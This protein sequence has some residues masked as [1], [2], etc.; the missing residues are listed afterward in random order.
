MK[1]FSQLFTAAAML[2]VSCHKDTT[3]FEPGPPVIRMGV[4]LPL[5]GTGASAGQSSNVSTVFALQDVNAWLGSIGRTETVQLEV[6][7]TRTDTAEALFQ[8]KDMYSRGIR[9]VVGPY[10]SAEVAAVK[11]FAD[12]HGMLVVSASSVAVS[13]AVPNDN[14]FRFVSSDIVQ[15]SAMGTMLFED[16]IRV[17]V[18]VIRNDVWGNDL[19]SATSAAFRGKGGVVDDVT[20]YDPTATDF[21]TMLAQVDNRVSALLSVYPSHQVAVYLCSFG[22]GSPILSSA[23]A[24]PNLDAVKWY[25]SSAFAENATILSDTTAAGFAIRHGFPCPVFGLD[26][27]ARNKWEPLIARIVDSIGRKP[28]VYALTAYDAI[29]VGCKTFLT[30]GLNPEFSTFKLAFTDEAGSYFGVSGNTTLDANGDRA[31]GNYDFWALT[32]QPAGPEWKVVAVYNSATGILT[33]VLK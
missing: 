19:L 15:G 4:L 20:R 10:S 17:I 25:G 7:D 32:P 30:A 22:E 31:A 27:S 33:R 24:Y 26:A 1:K 28:E 11:P 9:L 21:A 8:L 5:T 16:G 14:I 13:L 18:P 12:A 23:G 6:A 29:W 3:Y 2:L